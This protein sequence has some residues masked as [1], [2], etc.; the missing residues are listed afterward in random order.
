[1]SSSK[2]IVV[3][4]SLL[5]PNFQSATQPA[6]ERT[7]LACAA[8]EPRALPGVQEDGERGGWLKS[9]SK[10]EYGE[11]KRPGP[12]KPP[13]PAKQPTS[14]KSKPAEDGA[15]AMGLGYTLFLVNVAGEVLRVNPNRQFKSGERVRLLVETN[16]DGYIYVFSQENSEAPRLLFPNTAIRNGDNFVPGHQAFWLPDEG[17]IEFDQRP[18]QE[19]LIVVFSKNQVPNLM[20]GSQP[21]G[22]P[23]EAAV[24]QDVARETAVRQG[25]RLDEGT[26]LTKSEGQRGVRLSSKDPVPAFI[27]LN[28]DPT[29]RRIVA[30]VEFA[31][32]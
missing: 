4:I 11:G 32:R 24:F 12:G 7:R 3:L 19:R 22:V 23:V 17:E 30:K 13:R 26:L 9:R 16:C 5:L 28:Q 25:G 31:H 15:N 14:P 10:I 6:W 1:M 2:L 20:A 18:A 27:L 29:Q 8:R 21:E